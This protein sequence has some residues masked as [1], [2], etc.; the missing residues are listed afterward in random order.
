MEH[1]LP[2][3]QVNTTLSGLQS[4]HSIGPQNKWQRSFT[5]H[6]TLKSLESLRSV[7]QAAYVNIGT[8]IL[9]MNKQHFLYFLAPWSQTS[10]SSICSIIAPLLSLENHQAAQDIKKIIIL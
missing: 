8:L 4:H 7:S 5:F 1:K 6:A 10:S 9:L 2:V 3:T